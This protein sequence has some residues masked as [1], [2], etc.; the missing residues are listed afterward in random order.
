M[1]FSCAFRVDESCDFVFIRVP[2]QKKTNRW[3]CSI[4]TFGVRVR[5]VRR[6]WQGSCVASASRA[7][8]QLAYRRTPVQYSWEVSQ[9][10]RIPTS[11]PSSFEAQSAS[12]QQQSAETSFSPLRCLQFVSTCHSSQVQAAHFACPEFRAMRITKFVKYFC[13]MIGLQGRPHLWIKPLCSFCPVCSE[14]RASTKL[15]P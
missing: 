14:I 12:I 2:P 4:V 8:M 7:M 3:S 1:T 11:T 5:F 9:A 15:C 6:K 13:A 10:L